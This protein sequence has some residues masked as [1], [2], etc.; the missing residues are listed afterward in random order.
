MAQRMLVSTTRKTPQSVVSTVTIKED[1]NIASS[2][3]G[4]ERKPLPDSTSN[5]AAEFAAKKL[6]LE[7]KN[8]ILKL[9]SDRV[10][11]REA[12]RER[13]REREIR[14]R[15]KE[16]GEK[17]RRESKK[18]KEERR[19]KRDRETERDHHERKAKKKRSRSSSSSSSDGPTYYDST[20]EE[21]EEEEEGE[22][23][24]NFKNYGTININ[25]CQG[26]GTGGRLLVLTRNA[27]ASG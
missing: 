26:H 7:G 24:G 12:E 27:E 17:R 1:N 20:S 18:E 11:E 2:S 6:A 4:S 3:T 23:K 16:S 22:P 25:E 19:E 9:L 5:T 13:E 10:K 14:Q 8:R 15:E 21:E